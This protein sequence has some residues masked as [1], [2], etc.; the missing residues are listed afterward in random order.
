MPLLADCL[1]RKLIPWMSEKPEERF[2]V[3]RS[4]MQQAQMPGGVVLT[5]RAVKGERLIVKNRRYYG[6]IRTFTAR[7]PEAGL[8]EM[9]I[10]KV[11]II[12]AGR[13][14]YRL[15][16]YSIEC[17]PGYF[18]VVPPGT[19]APEG[20]RCPYNARGTFCQ[21]LVLTLYPHAVQCMLT[22][23]DADGSYTYLENYLFNDERLV[24]LFRLMTDEIREER[25]EC[26]AI[27]SLTLAAFWTAVQREIE[28]G[29]YLNPGPIGRPAIAN[30]TETDFTGELLDYIQSRLTQTLSL[31]SVAKGMYLSRTQF[32]RRV[33]QETG[34]SF[35]E[36]LND[37]RIEETKNLLRDSDWTITAIAEFLGFKSPT[38]LQR[39]FRNSTGKTPT[40]YRK[41]IRSKKV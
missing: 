7:Y 9:D 35:V 13:A 15:G 11:V 12:L 18:L 31:E 3:G 17:G 33:R 28:D 21:A 40:E 6:N 25:R 10:Y 20:S 27:A 29:K 34:K 5:R 16:N 36:F 8:V 26:K 41:W 19:P 38:Y 30:N 4:K 1:R 2:I 23:S 14:N 24:T 32:I 37:Y 39:V 22:R